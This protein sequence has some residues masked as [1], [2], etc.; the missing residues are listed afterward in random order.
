MKARTVIVAAAALASSLLVGCGRDRLDTTADPSREGERSVILQ[1]N[2]FPEAEHGGFYAAQLHGY[3][4]EEGLDVEI[5]PGGP[6]APV[7]A[8]VDSRRADFGVANADRI[9]LGR[10]AGAEV[11]ALM[12]PSI[13][14]GSRPPA[15]NP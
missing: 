12:A 11:V 4:R 8:Q 14:S 13:N 6:N 15:A 1:L 3:F 9:L 7:V 10:A 5:V 2:W